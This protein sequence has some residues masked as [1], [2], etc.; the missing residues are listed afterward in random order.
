MT[1]LDFTT[2]TINLTEAAVFLHI[3]TDTLMNLARAGK[4]PACK[5]GRRWVFMRS[6]LME[7]VQCRSTSGENSGGPTSST[8]A[9]GLIARRESW[10]REQR[11]KSAPRKSK[12]P[13]ETPSQKN[14]RP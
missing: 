4:V 11:A 2:E 1:D 10:Q 13:S 9:K 3:S 14:R 7:Y 5:I 12:P 8:A 6:L